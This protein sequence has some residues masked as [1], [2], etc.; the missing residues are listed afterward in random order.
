MIEN[1][2]II[3]MGIQAWDIEIGSNCKNIALEFA[4]N[5]RVLYVNPPLDRV[6]KYRERHTE[7]IKKRIR[8]LKGED[9]DLV[10]IGGTMWNLY[11][12]T[13]TESINFLKGKAFDFFNKRNSKGFANDILEAAES[14]GFKDYIVFNDSSMFLGQY[15]KEYLNPSFYVYYMRDYLTKNPYWKKNGVR[16]EPKLIENADCVVNNSTLYAEY[17]KQ[18]TEH[19]FMVGQG[20]DTSLFNDQ[21]R[22]I[23][24]PTDLLSI[25]KPIIGYVGFLSSRR[26]SI[27][28]LEHLAKARPDWSIVLVGPEDDLFS[29]SRLHEI[30]NVYFLG[31]RDSS[32]LPNYIKGFDVAINPQHI[33]EATMGNYPRKIDEYLA[34]GKPTVA[35]ATKAMEYFKEHTYLGETPEDYV[36]LIE[37]ALKE[38]STNLEASRR[39][40]GLSHSWENNVNEIYK[41]ILRVKENQPKSKQQWALS[42]P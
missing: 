27:N 24:I 31:S 9:D 4:K 33:N 1:Q 32:Q 19:S 5:N 30:D 22:E 25:P 36:V 16:L 40:F 37:K 14:L 3:V 11:P 13:L 35:S 12:K 6:S 39:E 42:L 20:C 34:M 29:V 2:D 17:G 10:Q 21:I 28:I 41:C 23:E 15:I 26:L 7:K 8:V 38:N 18:Y